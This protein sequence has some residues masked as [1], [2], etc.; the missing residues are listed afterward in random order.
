MQCCKSSDLVTQLFERLSFF[1]K[2][3]WQFPSG[4]NIPVLWMA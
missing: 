1:L 4:D 2:I 3:K